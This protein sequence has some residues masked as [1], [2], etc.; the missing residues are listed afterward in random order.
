MEKLRIML[1]YIALVIVVYACS[2]EA[3]YDPPEEILINSGDEN[4]NNTA[5]LDLNKLNG[6]IES[7]GTGIK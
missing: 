7:N 2:K 1:L 3:S 6:A 5:D 4:R